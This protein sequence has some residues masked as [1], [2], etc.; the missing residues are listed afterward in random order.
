MQLEN[1]VKFDVQFQKLRKIH[2]NFIFDGTAR[3]FTEQSVYLVVSA[4][5]L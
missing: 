5:L 4:Y 1:G 2:Q 3:T